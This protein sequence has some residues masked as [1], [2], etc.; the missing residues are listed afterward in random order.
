MYPL[1]WSGDVIFYINM[2]ELQWQ[3]VHY[4]G[5]S[6]YTTLTSLHQLIGCW[7]PR[8]HLMLG[9]LHIGLVVH[10][11]EVPELVFGAHYKNPQT[12]LSRRRQNFNAIWARFY[13]D[14][15]QSRG[16]H[17]RSS[18]QGIQQLPRGPFYWYGLTLIPTW[19]NN[20]IQYTLW[21]K[22]LSIPKLQRCNRWSLEW[23]NNF[24]PHFAR[25][26]V[27][28]PCWDIMD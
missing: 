14:C 26:M 25:H 23:I 13:G 15:M 4:V 27:I 2:P 19:V 6:W 5:C 10:S 18:E 3:S 22:Y 20:Y 24:T 12:H 11:L 1:K 9:N 28:Y 7:W 17:F 16:H 21:W 8:T